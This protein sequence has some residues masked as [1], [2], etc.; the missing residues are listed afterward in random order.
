ML[1]TTYGNQINRKQ[2]YLTK[3][4]ERERENRNDVLNTKLLSTIPRG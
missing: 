1:I 2:D 3:N 4:I